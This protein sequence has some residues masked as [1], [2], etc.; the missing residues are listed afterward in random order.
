MTLMARPTRHRRGAGLLATLGLGAAL[1]P[2][3]VGPGRAVA[4]GADPQA[5]IVGGVTVP[6]GKYPFASVVE[7]RRSDGALIRCSGS[8]IA[9]TWVLTAAHCVDAPGGVRALP[10]GSGSRVVVNTVDIATGTTFGINRIVDA[11]GFLPGDQSHEGFDVALIELTTAAPFAPVRLLPPTERALSAVGRSAVLLGV[12]DT[13]AQADAD[14]NGVAPSQNPNVQLNE[15]TLRI[16]A[17][18]PR[19]IVASASQSGA[20]FGDSGG[21]LLVRANDGSL[22]VAGVISGADSCNPASGPGTYLAD[23]GDQFD[24]ISTVIGADVSPD[25]GAGP[26]SRGTFAPVAPRRLLDTRLTGGPVAAGT[27]RVLALNGRPAGTTATALNVTAVGGAGVGTVRVHACDRPTPPTLSLVFARQQV[28]PNLV[29]V[30]ATADGRLCLETDTTVDLVVDLEGWFGAA[31]TGFTPIAPARRFDSRYGPDPRPARG[32]VAAGETV[33][34]ALAG[35]AGVS[36]SARS[37]LLNLTAVSPAADGFITAYPCDQPR[38]LASNLNP[39]RGQV[40]ANQVLVPLAANGSV[41][42]YSYSTTDLVVDVAGYYGGAGLAFSALGGVRVAD[43][44][45]AGIAGLIVQ[46]GRPLRIDLSAQRGIP[47]DVRAVSLNLATV[48]FG[49]GFLTVYP[50]DQP[51]PLASNLNYTPGLVRTNLATVPLAADGSVCIY[52]YRPALIVADLVGWY[53]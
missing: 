32:R 51:R 23:V 11:P 17:K 24:W 29:V 47:S 50:C 52:T 39:S 20:C 3:A 1:L 33:T 43:T 34:L 14:P 12:G 42:L 46:P 45:A 44:G 8:L 49:D 41:C 16:T 18:L 10:N 4:T 6:A 25:I 9:P 53:Q 15:A 7:L 28:A 30:P 19:V 22:R 13:N 37:V 26:G 2:L 48:S 36:P 21:S 40:V 5:A 31:G 27:S 38:P 35:S